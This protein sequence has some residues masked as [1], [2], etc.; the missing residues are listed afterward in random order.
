MTAAIP[1]VMPS[2]VRILRT[3]FPRSAETAEPSRAAWFIG[4]SSGNHSQYAQH[5][6]TVHVRERQVDAMRCGIDRHGV[7]LRGA[8]PAELHEG[9]VPLLEH[10]HDP[11]LGSDVQATDR[12]VERQDV[13]IAPHWQHLPQ[14]L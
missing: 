14:L 4:L 13:R 12:W 2:T 9:A 10:R 3:L 7:R 6:V 5:G 1:I 8:I 11:G